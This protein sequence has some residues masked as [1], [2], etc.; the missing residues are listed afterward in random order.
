MSEDDEVG[1]IHY[2]LIH[3]IPNTQYNLANGIKYY[4][5]TEQ[6]KYDFVRDGDVIMVDASEDLD[7]VNK[8]VEVF[9]IGNKKY[10]FK[11]GN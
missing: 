4:V 8:S 6:A 9:G 3:A 2:G 10:I 7:G 5:T 11:K 1:C